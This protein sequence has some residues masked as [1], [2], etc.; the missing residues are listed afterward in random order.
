MESYG[1]LNIWKYFLPSCYKGFNDEPKGFFTVYREVFENLKAQEERAFYD[2]DEKNDE[3]EYVKP[4]GFG[5]SKT[6]PERV[7]DFYSFWE[8]FS[9]YKSFSWADKYN[10]GD[11]E[12]RF[13]R[14]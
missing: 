10:P 11:G 14:R 5:D 6:T 8:N 9:T 2:E 7:A 3:G 4:P 1:D 13:V 12:N